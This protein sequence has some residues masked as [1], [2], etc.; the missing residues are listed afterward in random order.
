MVA[1]GGDNDQIY[2]RIFAEGL[3]ID[4]GAIHKDRST[5]STRVP[6]EGQDGDS[7]L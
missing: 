6:E 1:Q 5:R 3:W 4:V 7:R 2:A